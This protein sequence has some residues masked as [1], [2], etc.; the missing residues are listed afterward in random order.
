MKFLLSL[1][2]FSI[3]G[4]S[5]IYAQNLTMAQLLNIR[6]MNIGEVTD[7]LSNRNWDFVEAEDETD[8]KLGSITFAYEKS[9]MNENAQSF[10]IYYFSDVY[11]TRR[12]MIQINKKVKYTEF[13]NAIKSYGCKLIES[14]VVDGSIRQV[15]QGA[16]TTFIIASITAKNVYNVDSAAWLFQIRSN[17]DY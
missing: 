7:Y 11:D 13:V 3:L 8:E 12:V 16:T 1:I 17:D 15:Y 9:D 2:T 5:S 6:K 14:N 10:L 4:I